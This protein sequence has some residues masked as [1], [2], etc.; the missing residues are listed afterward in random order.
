MFQIFQNPFTNHVT[1]KRYPQFK[2][3]SGQ[4]VALADDNFLSAINDAHISIY[5]SPYEGYPVQLGDNFYYSEEELLKRLEFLRNQRER[6]QQLEFIFGGMPLSVYS[7][8][9]YN[10]VAY[11]GAGDSLD[12]K[13]V[14][15]YRDFF[16][17][18][19]NIALPRL[20]SVYDTPEKMRILKKQGL[21]TSLVGAGNNEAQWPNNDD[22]SLNSNAKKAWYERMRLIGQASS[23]GGEN[24][25]FLWRYLNGEDITP[26]YGS[27]VTQVIGQ[28]GD[29]NDVTLVGF[30]SAARLY[31]INEQAFV[32]DDDTRSSTTEFLRG[33]CTS[34]TAAVVLGLVS[35]PIAAIVSATIVGGAGLLAAA[36]TIGTWLAAFTLALSNPVGWVVGGAALIGMVAGALFAIFDQY[37]WEDPESNNSIAKFS[38]DYPPIRLIEDQLPENTPGNLKSM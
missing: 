38:N 23:N 24:G 37:D 10:N 13:D 3:Y 17:P 36:G 34:I 25:T 28:D 7:G 20:S 14:D 30:L 26:R 31:A 33:I 11:T 15:V 18:I 8:G 9:R 6:I 12:T 16:N 2:F 35:I 19:Y 5:S 27:E 22:G 21:D 4:R 29:G 32:G 1:F